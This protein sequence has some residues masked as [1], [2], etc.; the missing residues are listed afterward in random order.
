LTVGKN[1]AAPIWSQAEWDE[2]PT[3]SPPAAGN[4]DVTP[5]PSSPDERI[6]PDESFERQNLNSHGTH[7]VPAQVIARLYSSHFSNT[8]ENVA[9]ESQEIAEIYNRHFPDAWYSMPENAVA[10]ADAVAVAVAHN[11]AAGTTDA[12]ASPDDSVAS[13]NDA[14]NADDCDNADNADNCDN[15]SDSSYDPDEESYDATYDDRNW[16]KLQREAD[17]EGNEQHH[18]TSQRQGRPDWGI[19]DPGWTAPRAPTAHPEAK[20]PSN[21]RLQDWNVNVTKFSDKSGYTI[22]NDDIIYCLPSAPG[23]RV[24]YHPPFVPG[25][26]EHQLHQ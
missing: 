9:A 17:A 3:P 4:W 20:P 12:V 26:L 24:R 15:K 14:D 23:N 2:A 13:V 7:S 21:H 18:Y 16:R 10:D 5:T 8:R 11:T 22:E 1:F 19:Q 25:T 6:V